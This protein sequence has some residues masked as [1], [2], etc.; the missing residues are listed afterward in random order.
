M[1]RLAMLMIV[2]LP[3]MSG[4]DAVSWYRVNVLFFSPDSLMHV[5][6]GGRYCVYD[7]MAPIKANA[8]I[9][10]HPANQGSQTATVSN[11]LK[12]VYQ[13]GKE[14]QPY[15]QCLLVASFY[16]VPLAQT[17]DLEFDTGSERELEVLLSFFMGSGGFKRTFDTTGRPVCEITANTGLDAGSSIRAEPDDASAE[18]A[19][20]VSY[21]GD[22]AVCMVWAQIKVLGSGHHTL[23]TGLPG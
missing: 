21:N 1:K 11:V 18:F 9:V 4:C 20:E 23:T 3:L 14:P 12:D 7:D 6:D 15:D 16:D 2:L 22:D 8:E 13:E 5:D 10:I 19:S 17:Y